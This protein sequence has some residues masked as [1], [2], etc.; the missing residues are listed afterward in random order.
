MGI[1]SSIKILGQCQ[2]YLGPLNN[3]KLFQRYSELVSLID[4]LVIYYQVMVLSGFSTQIED[5]SVSGYLFICPLGCI[6]GESFETTNLNTEPLR[7]LTCL[8]VCAFS[9]KTI[10]L[11]IIRQ[12]FFLDY[13]IN[14]C[15]NA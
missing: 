12:S 11:Q 9:T 3:S 13:K 7:C 1:I 14:I 8:G 6:C 15:S 2:D 10:Y 4:S 5:H